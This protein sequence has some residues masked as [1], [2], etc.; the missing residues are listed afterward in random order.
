MRCAVTVGVAVSLVIAD[1]SRGL[2]LL[3]Q[4]PALLSGP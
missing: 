3:A 1:K 2:E 4:L